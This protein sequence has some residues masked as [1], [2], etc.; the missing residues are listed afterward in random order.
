MDS[1]APV[2]LAP[3]LV[4]Q[5]PRFTLEDLVLSAETR[6]HVLRVLAMRRH[7]SLVFDTWGLGALPHFTRRCAINLH[8]PPGTGKTSLAH[9]MAHALGRDLLCVRYSD[10]ESRYVGDTPQ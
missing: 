8:G 2:K 6:G 9:A 7:E 10:I 5:A 4:P 3:S 1:Y